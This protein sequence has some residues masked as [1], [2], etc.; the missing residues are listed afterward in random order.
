M[1]ELSI[2]GLRPTFVHELRATGLKRAGDGEPLLHDVAMY[3][4]NRIPKP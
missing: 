2:E 3:T 1:I 4:L